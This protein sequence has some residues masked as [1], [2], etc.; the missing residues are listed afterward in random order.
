MHHSLNHLKGALSVGV[1]GY[2][3]KDDAFQDLVS[4]IGTIREGWTFISPRLSGQFM[5]FYYAHYNQKEVL[6]KQ[7]RKVLS[8][9]SQYKDNEEI[10]NHLS[11]SIRTLGNHIG[12]IKKKLDIDSRPH[13]IRYGREAGYDGII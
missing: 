4:A 11:I 5:E 10:I 12:K 3:L 8:L 9:I 1:N 2:L 13:L 6:T 7:E